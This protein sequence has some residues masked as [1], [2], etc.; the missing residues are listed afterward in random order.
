M[1]VE[2]RRL[3]GKLLSITPHKASLEDLFFQQA[4]DES[5]S[6]APTEILIGRSH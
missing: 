2:I 1:V 3:G 6:P 5:S 4:T